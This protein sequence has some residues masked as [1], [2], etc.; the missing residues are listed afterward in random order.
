M[1]SHPGGGIIATVSKLCYHRNRLFGVCCC[2][3]KTEKVAYKKGPMCHKIRH[4]KEMLQWPN[5]LFAERNSDCLQ[6]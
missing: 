1:P 3:K 2:P 5:V 6:K 4:E